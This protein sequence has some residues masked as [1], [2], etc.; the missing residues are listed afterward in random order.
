MAALS[1][2]A[3]GMSAERLFESLVSLDPSKRFTMHE[4]LHNEMFF[5]LRRS[6]GH[7]TASVKKLFRHYSNNTQE[8]LPVL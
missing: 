2:T 1:H 5:S 6:S 7:E 3:D 4:A 8:V